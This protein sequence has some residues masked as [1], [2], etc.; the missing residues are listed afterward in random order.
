M[1][2]ACRPEQTQHTSAMIAY[3]SKQ[4]YQNQRTEY[5]PRSFLENSRPQIGGLRFSQIFCTICKKNGHT[6]NQCRFR[7]TRNK[8]SYQRPKSSR[9]DVHL[10][11]EFPE[12]NSY[13]TE[14]NN[15]TNDNGYNDDLMQAFLA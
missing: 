8:Q 2:K 6:N 5:R 15:E 12:D 11:E 3:R 1:K 13:P 9:V 14:T 7:Q 4:P 10:A